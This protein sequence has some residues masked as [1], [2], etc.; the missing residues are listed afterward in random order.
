[1]SRTPQGRLRDAVVKLIRRRRQQQNE[2]PEHD[3]A[4]PRG[5]LRA[6]QVLFS[7]YNTL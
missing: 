1:V 5:P 6:L 7:L 2:R 4:A 3:R